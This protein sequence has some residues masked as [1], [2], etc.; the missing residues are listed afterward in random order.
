MRWCELAFNDANRAT[1]KRYELLNEELRALGVETEFEAVQ[2]SKADLEP[3]LEKLRADF[4]AI[5]FSGETGP[6]VLPF[7]TRI[8]ASISTLRSADSLVCEDGNWW[9]RCFLVE[10]VNQT[11]AD[12]KSSIDL[13]GSVFI[14]GATSKARAVVAALSRIGFG[15]MIISDPDEKKCQ[16]FVEELRKSYFGIQ[17]QATPRTLVT[18]LPG[19]CSVAVNTLVD[20]DDASGVAELAYFNFLKVGGVWLD[21]ALFPLNQA[22]QAEAVSVG[23]TL[24]D[25]YRVL[26]ETDALWIAAAF[27]SKARPLE[28]FDVASYAS[29]LRKAGTQG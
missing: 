27:P 13:S 12:D 23:G 5:R 26:A 8:P 14:L 24:V 19:V 20:G 15:R 21:L 1:T 11:F 22:L 7:L 2:C 17:F 10:G 18:Q 9:P 3:T 29:R 28:K 25:G 6:A 16:A 4:Q